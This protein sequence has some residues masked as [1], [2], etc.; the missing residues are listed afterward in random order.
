M[1]VLRSSVCQPTGGHCPSNKMREDIKNR[2]L[3][4]LLFFR[5]VAAAAPEE[6]EGVEGSC[7]T[8][9]S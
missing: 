4:L 8:V 9:R 5:P 3:F 6:G 1:Y 2:L 7:K